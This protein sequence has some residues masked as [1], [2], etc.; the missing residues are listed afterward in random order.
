M[1]VAFSGTG[2]VGHLLPM[3]PLMRAFLAAGHEVAVIT[4]ADLAPFLHREASAQVTV[5]AAGPRAGVTMQRMEA[6]L[7]VSPASDPVP[8]VIA[9]FFAGQLVDAGLAEALRTA[10]DWRPDLVISEM[11]DHIGPFV[12]AVSGAPFYRHTFGPARPQPLLDALQRVAARRARLLHLPL[13]EPVAIIDIYPAAMQPGA[14]LSA[15][16]RIP[17]RP[18]IHRS[19][20]PHALGASS[21]AGGTRHRALVTFGTVFTDPDVRDRVADSLDPDRWDVVVTTGAETTPPPPRP[22]RSY[23]PFTPLGD[24]L[25][26]TDV[27]VTAGGAGTVLSALLAG[28]PMVVLPLGA[29]H[30]INAAR[31]EEAGV[32]VVVRDAAEVGAAASRIAA[33]PGFR[34]RSARI[35]AQLQTLPPAAAV[36]AQLELEH[37]TAAHRAR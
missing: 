9:E 6:D 16:R 21:T 37:R 26:G 12:A 19:A 34:D 11:L 1:R 22:S 25:P 20:Q 36:V 28:V 23:V 31:A 30:E 27:V 5:L 7:G 18:E 4:S 14:D 17:L 13:A 29:D 15:I 8:P 33:D 2:F 24:L 32:A 35:A 3:V 10:T